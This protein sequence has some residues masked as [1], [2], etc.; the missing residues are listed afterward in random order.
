MKVSF[1][2][3]KADKKLA[4]R[5]LYKLLPKTSMMRVVNFCGSFVGSFIAGV[6]VMTLIRLLYER[7]SEVTDIIYCLVGVALGVLLLIG[8]KMLVTSM[9][10]NSS[11]IFGSSYSY[12]P[13]EDRVVYIKNENIRTEIHPSA[14]IKIIT[15]KSFVFIYTGESYA[16]FVPTTAFASSSE[17]S[18]FVNKLEHVKSRTANNGADTDAARNAAQVTP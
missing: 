4:S 17:L 8:K 18:E 10:L 13:L 5:I 1:V 12:E 14:I 15:T 9:A 16:Y 6:S 11:G 7:A 2:L 3:S